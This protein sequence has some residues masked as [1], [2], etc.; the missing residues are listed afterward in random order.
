MLR[1]NEIVF[2]CGFA[3]NRVFYVRFFICGAHVNKYLG[4]V[5]MNY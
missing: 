3:I 4:Y 2:A 1:L 5:S